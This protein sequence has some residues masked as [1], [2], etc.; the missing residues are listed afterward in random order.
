MPLSHPLLPSTTAR[1]P[2]IGIEARLI[3]SIHP[4]GVHGT[5]PVFVLIAVRPSFK[6]CNLFE[7]VIRE[8][9]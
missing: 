9:K 6:V 8:S 3:N 1:V 7:D 2:A 5:K 4:L